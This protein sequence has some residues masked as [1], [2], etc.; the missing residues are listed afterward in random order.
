M[1]FISMSTCLL[2]EVRPRT[3]PAHVVALA[4]VYARLGV[5]TFSPSSCHRGRVALIRPVSVGSI[6]W[7]LGRA[8]G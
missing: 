5:G 1:R 4:A 7:I 3:L 6:P 8:D 2:D